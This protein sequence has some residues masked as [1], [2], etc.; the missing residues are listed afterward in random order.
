MPS[1]EKSPVSDNEMPILTGAPAAG[2]LFPLDPLAPLVVT[3]I[4]IAA[5]ATDVIVSVRNSLLDWFISPPAVVRLWT[6][7]EIAVIPDPI[8]Q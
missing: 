2:G 3:I 6:S 1:A 5:P 4:N 7:P 8:T